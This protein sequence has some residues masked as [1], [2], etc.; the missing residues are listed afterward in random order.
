MYGKFLCLQK[1]VVHTAR[2]RTVALNHNRVIQ[3]AFQP[4][5]HHA[6]RD[7]RRR[8]GDA[9]ERAARHSTFL[10]AVI[11]RHN[12][13]WHKLALTLN[14]TTDK[15]KSSVPGEGTNRIAFR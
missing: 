2:V 4:W 9:V 6:K 11:S 10:R 3:M 15:G 8:A 7:D 12:N 1:E 5:F 14:V 13:H